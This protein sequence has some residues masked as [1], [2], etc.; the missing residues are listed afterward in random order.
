V[1]A[2]FT[3]HLHEEHMPS[4]RAWLDGGG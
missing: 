2:D 1:E 3:G 4:V